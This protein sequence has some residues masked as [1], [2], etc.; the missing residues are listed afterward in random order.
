MIGFRALQTIRGLAT[1][2]LVALIVSA[3]GAA[4]AQTNQVTGP[5][6]N[7]P[8]QPIKIVVGL[9][10]GASPDTVAR[11]VAAKL[12]ERLGQPAVVENKPGAG[13]VI[14][15]EYVA[16]AAP[17]GHTILLAPGST[18]SINPAVYSK[19]PYDPHKSFDPIANI[20]TY[21]FILSVRAEHPARD[22]KG[23]V[24]WSQANAATAN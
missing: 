7:Y 6:A 3:A 20:A 19:L 13:G 24:A 1:P 9:T 11:L 16:R 5:A 15:A 10:A 23:L 17:D 8:R 21:A 14:A 4:T 2:V 12:G 22:V 18:L